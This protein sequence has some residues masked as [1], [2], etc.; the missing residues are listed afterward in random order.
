MRRQEEM[1]S[2]ACGE[3]LAFGGRRHSS[4]IVPG[5]DRVCRDES[6]FVRWSFSLMVSIFICKVGEIIC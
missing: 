3:G 2:K 6:T 5:E 4:I 1:E